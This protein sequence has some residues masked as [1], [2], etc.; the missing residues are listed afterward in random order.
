MGNSSHHIALDR[1]KVAVLCEY[2]KSCIRSR[3]DFMQQR[4]RRL[5]DGVVNRALADITNGCVEQLSNNL[6]AS[7]GYEDCATVI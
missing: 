1:L 4:T 7:T 6:G 5:L 3:R 2:S